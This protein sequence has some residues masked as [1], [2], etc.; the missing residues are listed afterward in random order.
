M[1]LL[2]LLMLLLL[3]R[4]L[5][6]L[7]L[8]LVLLLLL[9]LLFRNLWSYLFISFPMEDGAL[10][11]ARTLPP[12]RKWCALKRTRMDARDAARSVRRK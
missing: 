9:L 8:L 7:L 11:L 2:M 6:L 10:S 3:L 12:D 4:L 5:L 1:L